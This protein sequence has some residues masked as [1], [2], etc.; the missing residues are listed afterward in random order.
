M[1]G[2][3]GLSIFKVCK[4]TD[5]LQLNYKIFVRKNKKDCVRVKRRLGSSFEGKNILFNV[6]PVLLHL[7]V[8]LQGITPT[9]CRK[10]W[11]IVPCSITKIN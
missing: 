7:P 9:Q 11:L 5:V 10:V 4:N 8:S 3:Q 2:N 1:Y 6:L